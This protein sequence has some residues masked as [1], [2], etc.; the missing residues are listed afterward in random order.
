MIF[1]D[2][3]AHLILIIQIQINAKYKN[4]KL[5]IYTQESLNLNPDTTKAQ[6]AMTPQ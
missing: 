1:I 3:P 5:K 6:G 2:S 4:I